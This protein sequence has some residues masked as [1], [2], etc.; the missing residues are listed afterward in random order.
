MLATYKNV[1]LHLSKSKQDNPCFG[2]SV[3]AFPEDYTV[4]DL[5]TTGLDPKR[6]LIIEYA[7]VKV[8]GGK[9]V[10]TFQTLCDPGFPIPPQIEAIAP[11][12]DSSFLPYLTTILRARGVNATMGIMA[13]M[14]TRPEISGFLK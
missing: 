2:K 9:V 11:T 10:D 13:N 5:E 12:I 14:E 7:A 1:L 4:L 8:R 6:E 3:I